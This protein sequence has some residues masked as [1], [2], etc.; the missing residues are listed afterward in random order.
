MG[1]KIDGLIGVIGPAL[2]FISTGASVALSPWFSWYSNALS[3]LGHSL[4]SEVAPI[5][6]LG[7][8]LTG[9]LITVYAVTVF[10]KHAKYTGICLV[11]SA[12]ILQSIA[13]FDEVYGFLHFAVS[14]LF[15]V[16]IGIASIVYAVERRSLLAAIAFVVILSSWIIYAMTTYSVGVAVPETISSLAVVSW[17]EHSAIKIL[18]GKWSLQVDCS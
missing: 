15:F 7:L 6:N 12:F 13:T 16:S 2:A 1:Q 17:I 5:F 9:F 18:S 10:R 11:F 3:D 8:L 14:V 4:K